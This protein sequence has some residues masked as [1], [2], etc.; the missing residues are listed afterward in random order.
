LQKL[1]CGNFKTEIKVR[2]LKLTF[3][4]VLSQAYSLFKVR[5][6]NPCDARRPSAA[7]AAA[8]VLRLFEPSPA[9]APRASGSYSAH[10]Y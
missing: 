9:V 5:G 8:V 10:E 2:N 6:K 3:V 4:G 7:R 1:E